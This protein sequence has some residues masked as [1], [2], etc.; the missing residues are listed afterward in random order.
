[1]NK[2]N[3]TVSPLFLSSTFPLNEVDT[4]LTVKCQKVAFMEKSSSLQ[5]R[6]V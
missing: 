1:M 6:A 5:V 3:Y 2:I 4:K